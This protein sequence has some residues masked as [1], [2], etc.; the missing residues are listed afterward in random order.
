M[1]QKTDST[2]PSTPL[3]T[4]K[5]GRTLLINAAI[6]IVI[7]MLTIFAGYRS[8]IGVRK[9]YEASVILPQLT[10]QFVLADQDMQA[11][12]YDIAR[13]R[14]EWIISQNS[15]FPGAQEKLTDVFVQINLQ[16]GVQSPT[17]AAPTASATPDFSGVE[18]AYETAQQQIAAQD[19]VSA[20]GTLDQVRKLDATYKTS[21]VDGMYYFAF[22]NYGYD[23][24]TKHGNLEGGIYQ[25][26]LAERFGLLDRDA[27]GVREGARV[28]LIGAS[29]WELDWAQALFYFDQARNWNLSDGTSTAAKRYWFAAMRYGD[30]LYA[31]VQLC[32]D[33]MAIA[34]Y[35]KAMTVSAL[36]KTAQANYNDAMLTCYPP[37]PTIDPS[38]LFTPTVDPSLLTPIVTPSYP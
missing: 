5:R 3:R 19:W 25:I 37:T 35:N 32:G 26:T 7:L 2:Q 27:N 13:Q 23:L 16:Q 1:I 30:E 4:K 12:R 24:I 6:F 8:G 28:Y 21:Q 10:E 20:L 11:G 17:P 9:N 18:Q 31:K 38:S 22:R 36:D 29:F 14:L 34:Q 33:E 15:N